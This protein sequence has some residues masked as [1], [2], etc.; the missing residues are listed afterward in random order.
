MSEHRPVSPPTTG[1]LR[2]PAWQ[3][4][5]WWTLLVATV[6]VNSLVI[7]LNLRIGFHNGMADFKV[8]LTAAHVIRERGAAHVYDLDAQ[9]AV[10][11]VLY[12]HMPT[13]GRPNPYQRPVFEAL[14]FLP[15]AALSP[16]AAYMIWFT[17][18]TAMLLAVVAMLR[19]WLAVLSPLP[20]AALVLLPFAWVQNCNTLIHGQDAILVAWLVTLAYVALRKD[21]PAAAGILLALGGFKPHIVTP[22]ALVLFVGQRR[23]RALAAFA[24]TGAALGLLS[25]A[26]I[27]R[28]GVRGYVHLMQTMD[29]L[30]P[31]ANV[32]SGMVSLW[33]LVAGS[34][35][36]QLIPIVTPAVTAA[37]VGLVLVAI[38]YGPRPDTGAAGLDLSFALACVT[39][40]LASHHCYPHNLSVLFAAVLVIWN[41]HRRHAGYR[42]VLVILAVL[43]SWLTYLPSPN[44]NVL[45][46]PIL[47]LYGLLLVAARRMQV[48]PAGGGAE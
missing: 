23:W 13:H 15:L 18:N 46:I 24:A 48:A 33:G 7:V 12:P 34:A 10:Q 22:L 27:G 6:A 36:A 37:S 41:L 28:E 1:P 44:L 32:P 19:P 40:I 39:A 2:R 14:L 21:R 31:W 47:G 9:A 26:I 43:S 30:E 25:F 29:I 38:R 11:D 3:R 5:L 16:T 42:T 35:P 45:A 20:K 4:F 17:A 8:F